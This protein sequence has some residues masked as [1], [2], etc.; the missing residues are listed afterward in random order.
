M[1]LVALFAGLGLLSLDIVKGHANDG[2]L[3][4]GSLTGTLL[5]ELI[6]ADF[7]VEASPCKGPG[8][9]DSLDLLVVHGTGLVGDEEEESA[10]FGDESTALAGVDFVFGVGTQVSFRNHF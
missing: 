1:L 2:L 4:A 8:E 3:D 10:V 7:L 6:D 5:G 9:L